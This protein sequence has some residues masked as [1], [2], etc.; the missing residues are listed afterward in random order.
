MLYSENAQL[1]TFFLG[2][3]EDFFA[4][5][6]SPDESPPCI[7]DELCKRHNAISLDATFAKTYCLRPQIAALMRS[8]TLQ[9]V[10]R[11][12]ETILLPQHFERNMHSLN[13]AYTEYVMSAGDFDERIF[14][15]KF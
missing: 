15:G 3:P 10:G 6:Y 13:E 7:V 11:S 4:T 1:S 8:G 12:P 2:L 9:G 5:N 14:L